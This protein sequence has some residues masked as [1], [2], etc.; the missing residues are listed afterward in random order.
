M[1]HSAMQW[2][3]LRHAAYITS[4]ADQHDLMPRFD[5]ITESMGGA[6]ISHESFVAT[7]MKSA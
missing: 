3:R 5:L 4:T 1:S 6:I 2:K 7:N